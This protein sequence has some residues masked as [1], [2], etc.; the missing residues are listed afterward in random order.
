MHLSYIQPECNDDLFREFFVGPC[1][2][3]AIVG[4]T[5]FPGR[6]EAGEFTIIA[7]HLELLSNCD[8]NLPMM[9]WNHKKTLKD[10]EKRFKQRYL[11]LIVNNELKQ[12]FFKRT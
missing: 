3:G 12:F 2:R 8:K 6:T 10:S 4:I 9:N 1:Q 5:G 11:D 7:T